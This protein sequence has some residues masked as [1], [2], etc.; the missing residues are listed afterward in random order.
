VIFRFFLSIE[1]LFILFLAFVGG[2]G[3][4]RAALRAC[5]AAR[6]VK[7]AALTGLT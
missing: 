1:R 6:V 5:E 7:I 2:A 4:R 3:H